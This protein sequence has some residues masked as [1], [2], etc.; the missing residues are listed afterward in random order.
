MSSALPPTLHHHDNLCHEL[1]RVCESSAPIELFERLTKTLHLFTQGQPVALYRRLSTGTLRLI[2]CYPVENT[3]NARSP[4]LTLR[5]DGDLPTSGLQLY[6]LKGNQAVWGY[7][8]HQP[9][10]YTVSAQWVQLLVDIAS[11]RLRLLQ[12]E[13]FTARRSSLK[14]C[15]K[16][17]SSNIK[18][19]ASI[20]DILQHQSARWC[21]IFQA[22]GVT[23]C[24]Q[25]TFYCVGKSPP[26]DHLA[27]QL[28]PSPPSDVQQDIVELCGS[29]QGGLAAQLSVS[30]THLGWLALFRQQP[31][32]PAIVNNTAL[33]N[34]CYWLPIEAS[35]IAELAD[36]L[37]IAMA[38][39][40]ATLHNRQLINANLR[41]ERLAHIDPITK[42]WNRYYTELVLEKLSKS[43]LSFAML[44]FDIDDF[45]SINDTYGHAVG[46]DILRDLAC[47][48]KKT[49]RADDH[50]GR[51]GGEEF[52]IIAQGLCQNI[53]LQLAN[54]LC[55]SVEEYTFSISHQVTISLGLTFFRPG[56]H[57]R[58]LLE[59]VDQGMYLAK[60]SG[61]N[62]VTLC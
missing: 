9:T 56:E 30:N 37:A 34:P 35:M 17:L 26:K 1:T 41:L 5:D 2:Y 62:Q 59:R 54:R 20:D 8:G 21:D 6:E 60:M 43:T 40:E 25:N 58:K 50:L 23:L 7:I 52:I 38:A 12:D 36:D 45:K 27:Q 16:L 3:L 49:L 32:M 15:R 44:M 31:L 22:D 10:A 48:V 47:L 42:C 11:Q 29:C 4:L 46:D 14:Y 33:Q 55:R 28:L 53:S 13:S 57:P 18:N 61:K 19:V 51:W 39:Q 24:Y